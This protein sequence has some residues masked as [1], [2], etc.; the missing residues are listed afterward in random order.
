LKTLG[1]FVGGILIGAALAFGALSSRGSVALDIPYLD[2][3]DHLRRGTGGGD[4]RPADPGAFEAPDLVSEQEIAENRLLRYHLA[5]AVI[6]AIGGRLESC[7]L[8]LRDS[9]ELGAESPALAS[10]VELLPEEERLPTLQWLIEKFEGVEW[11]EWEV[12]GMY[13]RF[14]EPEVAFD[15]IA[16]ALAEMEKF[17]E[18]H[19]SALIRIYPERAAI[20]LMRLAE[21]RGWSASAYV[22][23]AEALVE[24]E[25]SEMALRFLRT[26][27]ALAPDQ[28]R[29]YELFLQ[30]DPSRMT[31]LAEAST[32]ENPESAKAW[33][34]LAQARLDAGDKAGAF[35]AFRRSAELGP[36]NTDKLFRSMI[37]CDPAAALP[38]IRA[39][40]E[41]DDEEAQGML[42]HAFVANGLAAEAYEIYIRAH[43]LDPDDVTWLRCLVE[44]N[45]TRAVELL[46]Q[47]AQTYTGSSRDELIGARGNA[48][49]LLGRNSDA[50]EEYSAALELDDDDWEWLQG[51]ASS[52]P[53]RAAPILEKQL[54][55]S[56]KSRNLMGALGDAYAAMGRTS[57]AADLYR[58]ALTSSSP[59]RR[60]KIAYAQVNP[61]AGLA[62]LRTDTVDSPE[63]DSAWGA[64]GD[65][66]RDLGRTAKAK[67]AY[68]KA[69]ALDP[70]DW[71]WHT[72]SAALR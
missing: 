57:E 14:G 26:A 11:D 43:S 22:H 38:A 52:D 8:E 44:L 21:E 9:V 51:I 23:I 46:G 66:Y 15:A 24:G 55:A 62:L 42:G 7:R 60:W 33:N 13:E 58:Q 69:Q 54:Q 35:E 19:A 64:L 65:A 30:I 20:L 29:A 16:G 50:F 18:K 1:F 25:Q 41:L 12:W 59:E 4:V 17:S 40:A 31:D 72:R 36:S 5:C 63:S 68:L 6:E 37:R 32:R 10:V 61:A 67:E 49:M 70:A 34:R 27:I 56:P 71:R 3:D 48:L 28:D 47:D 2:S 45:P 53:V 39:L